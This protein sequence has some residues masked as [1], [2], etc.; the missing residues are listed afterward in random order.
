MLNQWVDTDGDGFVD[1]RWCELVDAFLDADNP[2]WALPQ[3]GRMRMFLAARCIDLS[4]L[5]NVNTATDF[6]LDPGT[7][8]VNPSGAIR[9]FYPAGLTPSDI[10]L[11]RVLS[12]VDHHW[13]YNTG[14]VRGYNDCRDRHRTACH[15]IT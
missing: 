13:L 15:R 9:Q 1:A 6:T 5:V 3:Q 7:F 8:V 4:G 10:D 11:R 14:V 2:L 12:L